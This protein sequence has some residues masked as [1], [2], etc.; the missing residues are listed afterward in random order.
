MIIQVTQDDFEE[1]QA[2]SQKLWPDCTTEDLVEILQSPRQAAFLVRSEAGIAIGFMNLSLRYDYVPDASQSPV[3]FIE[4]IYVDEAYR[5]QGMGRALIQ[6]AEQ[7]AKS[8]GCVEVASDALLEN[9]DSHAFHA[10]AG[11]REVERVVFFIKSIV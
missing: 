1:W 9:T 4:G 10:S 5:Q 11:F 7:W 6:Y 3:A 2:L 8:Q